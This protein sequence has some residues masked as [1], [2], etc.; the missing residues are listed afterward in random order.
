[1]KVPHST[2]GLQIGVVCEELIL[3]SLGKYEHTKSD[4]ETEEVS[5]ERGLR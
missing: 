5:E 4:L 2:L 3:I 1:M